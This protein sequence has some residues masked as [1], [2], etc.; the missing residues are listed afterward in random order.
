LSCLVT[1]RHLFLPARECQVDLDEG[2]I[3]RSL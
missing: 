1:A 3:R 2:R